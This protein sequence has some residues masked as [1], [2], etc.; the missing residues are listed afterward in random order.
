M[1]KTVKKMDKII[2]FLRNDLQITYH[3]IFFNN[4]LLISNH[5]LYYK[6]KTLFKHYLQAKFY[7]KILL[8]I[9]NKIYKRKKHLFRQDNNKDK[10]LQIFTYI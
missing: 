2:V 5:Q 7:L 1:Y 6:N 4:L 10:F 8:K 9:K 3:I